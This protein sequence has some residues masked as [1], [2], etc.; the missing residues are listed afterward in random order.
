MAAKTKQLLIFEMPVESF[1]GTRPRSNL[2]EAF[3]LVPTFHSGKIR[4][5]SVGDEDVYCASFTE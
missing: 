2:S 4:F 3:H 5:G 1:L